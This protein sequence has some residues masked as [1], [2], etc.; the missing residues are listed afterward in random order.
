VK[1]V[2][3]VSFS[4]IPV[5]L[6]R[7]AR[8]SAGSFVLFFSPLSDRTGRKNETAGAGWGASRKV[9]FVS[10]IL[11]CSFILGWASG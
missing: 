7:E 6:V 1:S 9:S 3:S 8:L 2:S 10:F 11:S 4:F 5:Q